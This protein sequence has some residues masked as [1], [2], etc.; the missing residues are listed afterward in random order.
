MPGKRQYA[1]LRVIQYFSASRVRV[2][3]PRAGHV[4]PA[5]LSEGLSEEEGGPRPLP[6]WE[7]EPIVVLQRHALPQV[8][9]RSVGLPDLRDWDHAQELLQGQ[10]IPVEREEGAPLLGLLQL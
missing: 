8:P 2:W 1:V 3:P 10:L 4:Q 6:L 7:G 9:D 5:L